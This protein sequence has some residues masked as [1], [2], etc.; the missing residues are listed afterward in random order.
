NVGGNFK[1]KSKLCF[2]LLLLVGIALAAGIAC[3]EDVPVNLTKVYV[4]G[5]G[6]DVEESCTIDADED[7]T[8]VCRQENSIELLDMEKGRD[9]EV[10]VKLEAYEDKDD[11]QVEASIKGYEYDDQDKTS[12]ETHVFDVEENTTYWKN[13]EL[14][15]PDKMENDNYKLWIAVKDRDDNL[16][17]YYFD[18]QVSPE[19]HLLQI[20]DVV[21]SPQNGVRA[22]SQLQASVRVKNI[23]AKDEE[24]VKVS[25]SVPE[26]NISGS[27]YID[28]IEAG[29]TESN[30]EIWI[31][32]P[33]CAEEG[34]YEAEIKVSYDELY[35]ET[36]AVKTLGVTGD[37]CKVEAEEELMEYGGVPIQNPADEPE[38]GSE[39]EEK[40]RNVLEIALVALIVALAVTGIAV[41]FMHY[42]KNEEF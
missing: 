39:G 25:V 15:I 13:L 41:G 42:K 11:V 14:E 38:A 7:N 21:F 35:E 29:E 20:K 5:I 17:L 30:E 22:G 8:L 1:M 40:L 9:I 28:M 3:A 34:F 33:E 24:S 23:G 16:K 27:A 36:P 37:I 32:I 19:R 31:R 4:D 26:L 6:I 2:A 10:S 12:D 18:L